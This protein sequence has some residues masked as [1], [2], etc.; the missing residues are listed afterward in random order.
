MASKEPFI[1]SFALVHDVCLRSVLGFPPILVIGADINLVKDL[2]SCS[3]LNREFPLGLSL[4]HYLPNVPTSVPTNPTH[5]K[6]QL[7]HTAVEGI[8]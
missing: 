3:E 8:T 5:T 7:H 1:R 2:L 4:Y 6:L